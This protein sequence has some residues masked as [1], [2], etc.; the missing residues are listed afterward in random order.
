MGKTIISE[1]ARFEWDEDKDFINRAKHGFGFEEILGLFDDPY[2]LEYFDEPHSNWEES[3]FIGLGTVEGTLMIR[4]S[5]TERRKRIRI[6]S[7]RKTTKNE[8]ILYYEKIKEFID[9]TD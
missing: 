7:A 1:D 3:R 5:Y 8:E 2:L 4:A 6:F 9:G